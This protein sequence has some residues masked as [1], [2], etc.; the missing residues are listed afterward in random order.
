MWNLLNEKKD[1]LNVDEAKP[2]RSFHR[3]KWNQFEN[4][5]ESYLVKFVVFIVNVY[6]VGEISTK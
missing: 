4:R 3:T 6:F 1:G 2:T 5:I